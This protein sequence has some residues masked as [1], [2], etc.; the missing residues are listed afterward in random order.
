VVEAPPTV[1]SIDECLINDGAL[2]EGVLD[3]ASPY[4]S[5]EKRHLSRH[6]RLA[7]CWRL[8]IW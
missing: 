8:L 3:D 7:T 2:D 6:P 1:A 5:Y 4:E